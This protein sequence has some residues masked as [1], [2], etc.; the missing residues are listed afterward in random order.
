[1]HEVVLYQLKAV[2]NL[3]AS[4]MYELRLTTQ[5]Y[6]LPEGIAYPTSPGTYKIDFLTN[7]TQSG[8][9][10]MEQRY[11]DVVG[12]PFTKLVITQ[13]NFLSGYYSPFWV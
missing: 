3:Q 5:S 2:E 9:I 10:E 7:Y 13:F 1:M 4:V 6:N 12:T 8:V 11:I